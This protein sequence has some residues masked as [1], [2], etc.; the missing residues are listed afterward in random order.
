MAAGTE[1]TGDYTRGSDDEI[2][3][4]QRRHLDALVDAGADLLAIETI[5]N[6]REAA[7]LGELMTDVPDRI[8]GHV[9]CRDNHNLSD[10]TSIADAIRAVSRTGRVTAVGLNSTPPQ[11]V[12]SLLRDARAVTELP[13]VAYPNW[14]RIWDGERYEW[15]EGTG[16]VESPAELLERWCAAGARVIGG[17][18]GIGPPGIAG[19]AA[20]RASRR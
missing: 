16:V 6:G 5:P 3:E 20:W 8:V 18:C 17:C 19:V 14:G 13:L 2:A 4:E 9:L 1:Y 12:E 15:I 10:G 7:I 11:H